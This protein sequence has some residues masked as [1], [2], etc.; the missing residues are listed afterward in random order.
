[1]FHLGRDQSKPSGDVFERYFIR[2]R[3]FT[4]IATCSD[5]LIGKNL[6]WI[7]C[8]QVFHVVARL[9]DFR[10]AECVDGLPPQSLFASLQT[11][12]LARLYF[13]LFLAPK[14]DFVLKTIQLLAY[15]LPVV[16]FAQTLGRYRQSSFDAWLL[17]SPLTVLASFQRQLWISGSIP[18]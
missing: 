8:S 10:F 3:M 6:R 13:R 1:M 9:S 18:Y 4:S 17:E 11:S 16:R 15:R 7:L 2:G 14:D 12:G 5:F